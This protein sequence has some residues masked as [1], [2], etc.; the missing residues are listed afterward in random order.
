M[1]FWGL[2]KGKDPK[3]MIKRYN[4]NAKIESEDSYESSEEG[5]NEESEEDEEISADDELGIRR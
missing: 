1:D 2:K 5:E 3:S 4:K